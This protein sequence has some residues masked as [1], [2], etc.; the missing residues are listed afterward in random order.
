MNIQTP[1]HALNFVRRYEEEVPQYRYCLL[2]A[3]WEIFQQ[4]SQICKL[5]K[6]IMLI[7]HK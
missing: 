2:P 6:I 7:E 1:L 3:H 5:P 4:M